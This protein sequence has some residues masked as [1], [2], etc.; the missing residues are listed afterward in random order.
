[1]ILKVTNLIYQIKLILFDFL[2]PTDRHTEAAQV[3]KLISTYKRMGNTML[4][5]PTKCHVM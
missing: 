4:N 5:D 1:M 2:V 3:I